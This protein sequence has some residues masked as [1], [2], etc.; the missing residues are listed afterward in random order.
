M[1]AGSLPGEHRGGRA[2]GTRN[3]ASIARQKRVAETGE[4]PLDYMLRIMRDM[5]Q[6]HS[7]RD[8]M[9]RAVAPYV[10]P[11]LAST[12]VKGDPDKPI[13]HK[14]SIEFVSPKSE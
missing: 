1:P 3:H 9:A 4:T 5:T 12:E 14:L 7:R 10:H 8:E 13:K 11:K 6:E 2:K